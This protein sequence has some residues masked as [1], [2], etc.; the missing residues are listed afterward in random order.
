MNEINSNLKLSIATKYQYLI[1]GLLA[2]FVYANTLNN[3]FVLDDDVV[4]LKNQ[5]VQNGVQGIPDI[6]SHGFLY[7]FNQKNDQ[8]YRPLVL[9]NYAIFHS[10]LGNNAKAFHLLNVLYFIICCLLLFYWLSQISELSIIAFWASLLF[11]LHPIHTEVVANI[12]GT[13]EL[14]HFIFAMLTLI[15]FWK[16]AQRG[17]AK[18][19]YLALLFF[20]LALLC[21]EIALTLLFIAPISL[22]FFKEEN[23]ASIAKRSWPLAIVV[24]AYFLVRNA[25]LDTVAFEEQMKV[26]NNGIAA[27][28][29][30]PEQ[31]AT[32]IFIFSEYIKLLFF[33]HPLAWDY[34]YPHFPIVGFN[35]WRVFATVI[36]FS[37]ALIGAIKGL[38]RGNVY[39][40]LFFFFCASFALTSNF[41]ILIGS[42][43]GERF[44]F[45]PSIAFVIFIPMIVN[46]AGDSFNLKTKQSKLF[47]IAILGIISILFF[48][49]TIDRNKDWES[50]STLFAAGVKATPNN[51]RAQAAMGSVYREIAEQNS[52]PQ[53]KQKN[54]KLAATHY[55]MSVELLHDNSNAWY[56]LGVTYMGMGNTA[57]AKQAFEETIQ[58]EP[59]Y[60]NALNNLGVLYFNEKDFSQAESYFKRC[61]EFNVNFQNAYANL[62]AVYHNQ[63][64]YEMARQFYQKALELNP[65]DLNVQQN[66]QK[67][68]N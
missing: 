19:I 36:T 49:K 17:E 15:Y 1:I 11:A 26:I 56:N 27:A 62:G 63:G 25:I 6:L 58:L 50:N 9:I 40:F 68:P 47:V 44:L 14:L 22:Y 31:L 66:L 23:I 32:T 33:P 35:H 54:F 64:Q 42:T 41:I 4:F 65:A 3:G 53:L 67:L 24:V 28:N 60:L 29:S 51:S 38:K 61:L 46:K 21:K 18:Q 52:N 34:S 7:G 8:S 12:K 43:L 57:M 30:Y 5:F 20:G 13:D 48:L 10:I 45:F 37:L 55:K 39:S 2:F 16:Y 59:S